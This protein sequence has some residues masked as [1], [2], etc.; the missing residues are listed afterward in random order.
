MIKIKVTDSIGGSEKDIGE[1]NKNGCSYL[2]DSVLLP[3]RFGIRLPCTFGTHL[4]DSP[5]LLSERSLSIPHASPE[6]MQ[7]L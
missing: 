7:L 3:E 5:E 4:R 6:T 2:P 1:T